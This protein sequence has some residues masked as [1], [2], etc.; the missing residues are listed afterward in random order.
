MISLIGASALSG[1]RKQKLLDALEV[2]G[3]KLANLHAHYV[4]FIDV[5]GALD[6]GEEAR[7]VALLKDN[8]QLADNKDSNN[9]FSVSHTFL[10]VPRI[11]TITPWSTK[12]TD[13]ANHCGLQKVKRIERGI[14]W[15]IQSRNTSENLQ[16]QLTEILTDPMTESLL[17][18]QSEAETIF[19]EATPTPFAEIDILGGGL[20]ALQQANK[21]SGFALS[22]EEQ[23]YLFEQFSKLERNPTDAELMM[24]A[25]VNSEHCRHK[26][27]NADWS[28]DGQAKNLSPFKM[29]KHTHQQ[30]GENT[31]VAYHD[32]AAVIKGEAADRFFPD[33]ATGQ[34]RYHHEGV[35]ICIKVETH[36]HP[37]AISPFPGA[38]TGS[39]GEIRD[40]GATGRGG[41]PKV[42]LTGF[43]VSHLRLPDLPR[44]WEAPFASPS[45]IASPLQIMLE[46]PIGGASFN[47][48]FGRPNLC[49]YFRTFEH[50]CEGDQADR[51]QRRGYHKPI[52][53]A[54]GLGNIREQHIDKIPFDVG[55]VLIVLGGPAMLIGLGG[56]AASSVA[57]GSSSEQLDFASVQRGNPEMQRRCQEVIDACWAAG[58]DNP[59]LWIHDVGAGGLSNALP[60]L[61]EDSGRSGRFDLRKILNDDLA[62][63]PM[64]IWCNESQERYVLAIAPESL[65]LFEATCQRERALYSV[66][67][68]ATDDG[69]LVLEDNYFGDQDKDR[70]KPIDLPMEVLFGLPPKMERSA[71]RETPINKPLN[72]KARSIKAVA[73]D[74]LR[75]PS[76]ADK[77]FL[78]SIGDRSITGLIARDQM[79]GPWQ[80]PVADVAVSLSGF[81]TY[82]GE[83]MS[84]GERTPLAL[85][86][87]AASGRM[88]IGEALTNIAAANIPNISDIKLSANWMVPAG[89]PGEDANLYD[90]VQAIALEL[91]PALGIS[92]PVG[93]D[94]M[95]MQTVWGDKGQHKVVSPLSLVVSAFAPVQD[96]RRTLTPQLDTSERN[97]PLWLIDLGAGKHRLGGS[98]YAQIHQQ[99]GDDCPD[100]DN[101][102]HLTGFYNFIQAANQE[103]G[104]LAYHD[105]SDGGLLATLV[106]M[107]F[108]SRCGLQIDLADASDAAVAALFN[109]EL[110][111][112]VQIDGAHADTLNALAKGY[113]IAE[114]IYPIGQVV[115]NK[116]ITIACQGDEIFC[117]SR[118]DLHRAWSETTWKMQSLRDNPECAQQE[119]DRLLDKAD[120]GLFSSLSFDANERPTAAMLNT[121][122]KPQVA[123][124]REQGVNGQI[125]MAAAFDRAG[126]ES[127]D[128]TMSDL[129]E[130][131]KRLNQFQGFVACGGFSFGDVLGAGEGWAKSILFNPLL[132]DQF[133]DYF[134]HE[135]RFALGV[136]N[137]CQMLSTLGDIIPGSEYWPRFVRN[138]S[139]QFE[140]RYVMAKVMPSPSLFFND[141]AGS[142][143]PI[144]VAHGEGKAQFTH[145]SDHQKLAE[146]N[147][148]C[149]QFVDY[150]GKTA[151]DFPANPN[152]SPEGLTGITNS[153]G[154]VTLTMPH[155][156]RTTRTINHSWAPQD[157]DEISPWMRM[158][159]NAYKWVS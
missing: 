30:N 138:Q 53:L 149:L 113:G 41:K 24:F 39:G 8:T 96:A 111:A 63:S 133:A 157:W 77:T 94:S 88:A 140:G 43:S 64:Q 68:H 33:P 139:E 19:S 69:K 137:G 128:V 61:V 112:V 122:D 31:L 22:D 82:T 26:I 2:S 150:Q 78:I 147:Q 15:Q 121:R 66:V 11:G 141:M 145:P 151:S 118:I 55:A 56:G 13:I 129:A 100:V 65:A 20:K 72:I 97:K 18:D 51:V 148:Q 40:E 47:N 154:L 102:E 44:A 116:Q 108:T 106:E 103:G 6:A 130:G 143:I 126:F 90:T 58:E 110:G 73:L 114:L 159:Y 16:K 48:E 101:A 57:S 153:S 81:D 1:F 99:M 46:G 131:R 155:P 107:A 49:G 23:V 115:S 29:I 21:E 74:I 75:F 42:G 95:S 50:S 86:N 27:F 152:G 87:A 91:C 83:S 70:E 109:E 52:M 71:T 105:R 38:A 92:I 54:G 84:I 4:H 14:Q 124:L 9:E 132:H 37:T 34:Y 89:E 80:V 10:S 146:Q 85:I 120:S 98:V 117:A 5:S 12:A 156:E 62:M 32:N 35:H 67:G 142:V 136:C 28:I 76:V 3:I 25:L 7:L 36:N 123:I 79:V 60:E 17:S 59:I 104:L 144:A 134:Q 135:D 127:I 125:E 45:R 158:F 119:Y 93:K